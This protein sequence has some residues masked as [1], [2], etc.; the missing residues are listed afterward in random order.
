MSSSNQC[1]PAPWPHLVA[2][3]STRYRPQP[4]A[5]PGVGRIAPAREGLRARPSSKRRPEASRDRSP[6][7]R[8]SDHPDRAPRDEC[9]W[10]PVRS[11]ALGH[12]PAPDRGGGVRRQPTA[13]LQACWAS[14]ADRGPDRA[15]RRALIA[16]FRPAYKRCSPTRVSDTSRRKTGRKHEFKEL[17][18]S[19]ASPVARSRS[20]EVV[21]S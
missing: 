12:A 3:V 13:A 21:I 7:S 16:S 20:T 11:S 14:T 15:N 4:D 10:R 1:R 19:S 5:A 6:P 9:C 8:G 2:R 18:V 17:F